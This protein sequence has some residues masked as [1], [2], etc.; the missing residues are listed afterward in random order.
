MRCIL[1]VALVIFVTACNDGKESVNGIYTNG[2]M[3]VLIDTTHPDREAFFI[4]YNADNQQVDTYQSVS[5]DINNVIIAGE[6]SHSSCDLN[7][8]LTGNL[9]S[10]ELLLTDNSTGLTKSYTKQPSSV[11][12]SSIVGITMVD[13]H[14][15]TLEVADDHSFLATTPLCSTMNGTLKRYNY[16]Y[17]LEATVSGCDP[18]SYNGAYTGIGFSAEIDNKLTV[19][20]Y[21]SNSSHYL[22]GSFHE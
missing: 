20:V 17:Q 13:D 5:E 12:I 7:R 15:G 8:E 21:M 4:E 2:K 18:L 19:F 1:V 9:V 6:C 3:G 14:S 16:Y 22:F 11:D 10:G